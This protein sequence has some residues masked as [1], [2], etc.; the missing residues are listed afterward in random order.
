LNVFEIYRNELDS[1]GIKIIYD[2]KEFHHLRS[3]PLLNYFRL[4]IFT[5]PYSWR[6]AFQNDIF[7][8]EY[9][10][11]RNL[12][13]KNLPRNLVCISI[14][15]Y[16][17]NESVYSINKTI[18]K[19]IANPT[20]NLILVLDRKDL[21]IKGKVRPLDEEEFIRNTY[22]FEE[23]YE[24]VKERYKNEGFKFNFHNSHN[25]YFQ[26]LTILISKISNEDV[27]D[28]KKM[29]KNLINY[30]YLPVWNFFTSIL[31]RKYEK[32]NNFREMIENLVVFFKRRLEIKASIVK[33]TMHDLLDQLNNH[34]DLLDPS[35]RKR[36]TIENFS[37]QIKIFK[38]RIETINDPLLK[39]RYLNYIENMFKN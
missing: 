33:K 8:Y 15:Y 20:H 24:I 39:M 16:E 12:D 13:K 36:L 22:S 10:L 7:T 37:E 28:F 3:I 4:N 5:F 19:F 29:F 38:K 23:L 31:G 18:K 35:T 11:D 2:I 6:K 32:M 9:I 21:E 1:P 30:P 25:L 34:V 14:Q 26:D 27:R 17:T